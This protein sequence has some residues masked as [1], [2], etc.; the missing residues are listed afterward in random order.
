MIVLAP[1]RVIQKTLRFLPLWQ[2][3]RQPTRDQLFR[4]EIMRPLAADQKNTPVDQG[5]Q[6]RRIFAQCGIVSFG[7]F[8]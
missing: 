1:G 3:F 8:F 7:M 6:I 2:R 4:E 5:D